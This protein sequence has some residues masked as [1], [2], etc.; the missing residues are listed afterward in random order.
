MERLEEWAT[1]HGLPAITLTTYSDV[2]WNGPYYRRLGFRTLAEHEL[3]PA[4]WG[5]RRAEAAR[6]L[7]RWTRAAMRLD[8][9]PP[10][11]SG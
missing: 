7:D 9:R 10:A 6:G 1:E 11:P 8:L 5:I 2:P 3:T 4:L